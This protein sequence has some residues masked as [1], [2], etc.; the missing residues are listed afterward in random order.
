MGWLL[1]YIVG[2]KMGE[3]G[4]FVMVEFDGAVVFIAIRDVGH[5]SQ[6]ATPVTSSESTSS[7]IKA[8]LR[9]VTASK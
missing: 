5:G 8:T 1:V 2:Y 6:H 4:W 9:Y 7:G 3:V